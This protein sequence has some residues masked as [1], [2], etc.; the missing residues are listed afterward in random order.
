MT[1]KSN[2]VSLPCPLIQV[3]PFENFCTVS[4]WIGRCDI[5]L[6]RADTVVMVPL[7]QTSDY[8]CFRLLACLVFRDCCSAVP[9]LKYKVGAHLVPGSKERILHQNRTVKHP[10]GCA[11]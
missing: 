3:D 6:T 5:P 8:G 11:Q 7:C 9:F 2:C 4:S 1:H 10:G